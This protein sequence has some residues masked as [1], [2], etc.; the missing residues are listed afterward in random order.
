MI[1]R[2]LG[3]WL[4][5]IKKLTVFYYQLVLIC[6]ILNFYTYLDL[7]HNENGVWIENVFKG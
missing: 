7:K 6:N 1:I 3:G 5:K 2:A 4:G